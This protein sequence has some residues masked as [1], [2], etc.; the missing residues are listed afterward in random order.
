M[1]LFSSL[2]L[3][4]FLRLFV[5]RCFSALH[6]VLLCGVAPVSPLDVTGATD[7]KLAFRLLRA[8]LVMQGIFP[9]GGR[10]FWFGGLPDGVNDVF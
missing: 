4:I 5:A 9:F 8:C 3:S 1:R 10:F 6:N 2:S 7:G